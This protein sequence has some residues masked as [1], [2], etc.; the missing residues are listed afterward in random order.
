MFPPRYRSAD[1]RDLAPEDGI[2]RLACVESTVPSLGRRLVALLI[3]WVVAA[4]CAALFFDVSYPPESIGQNNIILAFY[5][6]QVAI[7]V[8]LLGFSIGKRIVGLR[9]EN[10]EGRPIGLPR[11]LLRTVLLSLVLP[12]IVM[13][14]DKRGLHDLAAGSRVVR[15]TTS[16]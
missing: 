5:V 10:V 6:G 11:A 15:T 9:V 16:R 4:M 12:A 13:T 3:D 7:L 2:A 8:G 1:A 14:D